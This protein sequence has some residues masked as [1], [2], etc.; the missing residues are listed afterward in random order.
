MQTYQALY[1]PFIHFKDDRWLKL[2]ALYREKVARIVPHDYVTDDSATV[3]ALAPCIDTVRPDWVPPDF[4]QAFVDF[5]AQYGSK[6]RDQ[7]PALDEKQRPPH[8]GGP[9]GNDSRRPPD[10][11]WG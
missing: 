6:L 1:Y 8:A 7:W 11:R 5:L 9:S 2:A 10:W 4:A 3:K